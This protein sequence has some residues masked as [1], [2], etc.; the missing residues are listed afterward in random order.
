MEY[1]DV[2][3][4]YS[5]LNTR[6]LTDD[7]FVI[8]MNR[9]GLKFRAGQH[10]LLG[11]KGDFNT[12]EYSIYSGENDPYLE[13][14]VKEVDSG[15]LSPKLSGVQE[16]DELEVHGPMGYFTINQK[17]LES[18]K[19]VLIASGTGIAP[20][21]SFVHTYPHMDY[22]ILHGIR[23][24]S[25]AYDQKFYDPGRYI[26]CTSR[27]GNGKYDGRVTDYLKDAE[28]ES[29]TLFYFCGN[30]QMIFDAMDILK[31]KGFG[32]DEMF[33]EIYF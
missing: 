6:I 16:G 18:H 2:Q 17:M 14:L 12:R 4:A 3:T 7:T 24:A 20:F 8:R 27:D 23:Y 33:A 11:L 25:E 26:S 19:F 21:K 29:N 32:R 30:S 9:N 10:I 22:T 1:T 13:V 5:V 31:S 15:Y 28:F